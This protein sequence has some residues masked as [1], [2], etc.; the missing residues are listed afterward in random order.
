MQQIQND[1]DQRLAQRLVALRQ[2][3][4]WSL[5]ALAQQTG[6]SRATLSRIERMETSPTASLLNTLCAAYGLTMSRLLSELDNEPPELLSRQQ[7]P[8]W[9]DHA[10]GFHRRSVSP[11]TALYQAEFIEGTLQSGAR[12]EYDAPSIHGLEHHLWMID[13]ELTLTLDARPFRLQ[14]G[15]CLRY[16]LTGSSQFHA[17]GTQPAHYTIIICRP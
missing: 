1:I 12:I 11:P 10:S 16:R 9:V 6:I 13:G 5:E 7:Q 14:A 3:R 4:G 17:T 15:D 2:Q 8:V